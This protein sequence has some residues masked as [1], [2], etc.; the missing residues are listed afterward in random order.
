MIKLRFTE[1]TSLSRG[2]PGT[3]SEAGIHTKPYLVHGPEPLMREA[4]APWLFPEESYLP[5]GN[6]Q[7]W[8]SRA[9]LILFLLLVLGLCHWP[10]FPTLPFRQT[11]NKMVSSPEAH[12]P[13]LFFPHFT[14]SF[15]CWCVCAAFISEPVPS[16]LTSVSQH[17]TSFRCGRYLSLL[18]SEVD[19]T[20]RTA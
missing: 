17:P 14:F 2:H 11:V 7:L 20:K 9:F 12:L 8:A 5:S 18:V 4:W 19:S 6:F 15:I 16:G 10:V 1:F 3:N 13:F